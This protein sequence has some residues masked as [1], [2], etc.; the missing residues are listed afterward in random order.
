MS[1]SY[2]ESQISENQETLKG[3]D[4]QLDGLTEELERVRNQRAIVL[5]K[6]ETLKGVAEN[7]DFTTKSKR[8]SR[9]RAPRP[10]T[11][12]WKKVLGSIAGRYPESVAYE[13]VMAI[14]ENFGWGI[15]EAS[16]RAQLATYVN[17]D[18][19]VRVEPGI[20]RMS[21]EQAKNNGIPIEKAPDEQ[22]SEAESFGVSGGP[23]EP[24]SY[25]SPE[26]S[27]PSNSTD[28]HPIHPQEQMRSFA[29]IDDDEI[30]F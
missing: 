5:A 14:I 12:K 22:T 18:I 11:D 15:K 29:D 1:K 26:G 9:T 23:R 13:D 27:I 6:L 8:K 25:P 19:L 7:I 3:L 4:A 2:I 16:V 21:P 24:A 10:L 17:N 30:P 20:F 28:H